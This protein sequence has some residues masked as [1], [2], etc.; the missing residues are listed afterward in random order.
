MGG[1]KHVILSKIYYMCAITRKIVEAAVVS[2]AYM[3]N[4]NME[5]A[6]IAELH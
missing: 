1:L 3:G 2:K 6:I 5:R 4:E